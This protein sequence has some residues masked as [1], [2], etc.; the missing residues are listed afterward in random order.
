MDCVYTV[1]QRMYGCIKFRVRGGLKW[2]H[3]HSQ[4]TMRCR[5][6]GST[7]MATTALARKSMPGIV[8]NDDVGCPA[9]GLPTAS[10]PGTKRLE[11]PLYDAIGL[12][13]RH[14]AQPLWTTRTA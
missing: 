10:R 5:N 8:T 2:S 14:Q 12:E 7:G 9:H 11:L 6:Q 13:S 4:Y 3:V 1:L